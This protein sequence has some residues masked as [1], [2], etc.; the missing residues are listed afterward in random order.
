QIQ[1]LMGDL[2]KF[3]IK[4]HSLNLYGICESCQQAN[5]ESENANTKESVI[6][7]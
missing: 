6:S 2:L 1:S 4:H 7:N 3:D 5:A